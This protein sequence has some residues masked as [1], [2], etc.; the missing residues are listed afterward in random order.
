MEFGILGPLEVVEGGVTIDL[1]GLKQRTLLAV[2]LLH[3][4]EVVSSD[5]LIEALWQ[6]EPPDT[7]QKAVQVY[8]SQL[9]K[10][11]GRERLQ[12]RPPGYVLRVDEGELDLARFRTLRAEE[13]PHEALSIWRGPPLGDFAYQ[14][15]AQAEIARL[16]EQRLACLEDRIERD[17]AAG[18]Q[19]DLVGELEELVAD[20]PLRERL[21]GQLMLALYRSGRQAEALNA[22]QEARTALVDELGIEPSRELRD[23]HQAILNQDPALDLVASPAS[24]RDSTRG[25]FVGREAELAELIAGLDDAIAGHGRLFLLVGEPGIGKSRL[26]DEL[27]VR[28]R[29]RGAGV[30]VGRCW[31]AGGAPAYWPWVQS[32]RN[33][34]RATEVDGLR[35]QLGAGATDL[36]QLLPELRELFPDLPE[37][38][39]F[40]SEGARFRLFGAASAFLQSAAQSRPL[41]LVLDDL[42]AADEP[43]LLL[44]QFLARELG[45]SRLLVVAAYRNVDPTPADPLTT[46]LAELVR[47]PMTRSVALSGLGEHEVRR[48]IELTSGESPTDELVAA[49]HEETEGNPLFVVEIVRLLA[50]EGGI[51]QAQT[52]QLAIPQSVRDVIVRRLRHLSEECNRALVLASVLGREFALEA[53]ARVASLSQDELLETLDEAMAAGVVSDAPGD[54]GNLRFAHVLI[55][56]VLYEE[57]PAT[58]RMRLHRRVAEV[59]EEVYA[60]NLEPHLTELAYHFPLAV[61]AGSRGKAIEY[62]RRA[63]D[64]AVAQLAF[65]EAVQLYETALEL[66]E[67]EGTRCELLLALGDA[68][69]RAGDSP[70]AQETF[71]VTAELARERGDAAALALAALGYGGRQVSE[72]AAEDARLISLLEEASKTVGEADSALRARVLARL[73]GALRHEPDRGPRTALSAEAVAIARRVGDA[74]TLAYTLDGRLGAIWW[75]GNHEERLALAAELIEL[76]ASIGDEERAFFGLG[77]RMYAL[78]ELG[79]VAASYGE[80]ERRARIAEQLRQ[81]AQL[82]LV[83]A[84]RGLQSLLSGRFHEAEERVPD[85]RELGERVQRHNTVNAVR[86]QLLV[87]HREQGR[88]GDL[89]EGLADSTP[90]WLRTVVDFELEREAKARAELQALAAADFRDVPR[91]LEWQ[92]ILCLLAEV[93]VGLGERVAAEELYIELAPYAGMAVVSPPELCLGS[94]DRYLGAVASGLERWEDAARHFEH[95]LA[96]NE[97]MGAWPWLAHTQED[98]GRMLLERG[99]SGRGSELISAAL[100][101][102]RELG[103]DSYAARAQELVE[104]Y[105]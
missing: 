96:M 62:A 70:A 7:A 65:Q 73:A 22:Y 92:F 44:L 84:N 30:L 42:H 28:A 10:L 15:F 41:L 90:T 76:A 99:D 98:F 9:R 87:L 78:L 94:I 13:R 46:A 11:L 39:A 58:H 31:E 37:P 55:R 103:M 33:L 95:A 54:P 49:I 60:A 81:P 43:S 72:S 64:R 23:L 52:P 59:L 29:A 75:P 20:H 36:A 85:L 4:N 89:D 71:V 105:T 32:L 16:Q 66:V 25:A 24:E 12:T 27:V 14:Q 68:Q 18:L 8:V 2:L 57:I 67:D 45:Q 26:A 34:I 1:G 3:A 40:E 102:Y 17:L 104:A 38:P 6:D 51:A 83:A 48:F 79:E 53:L 35:V 82:W 80:L 21:R 5:R 91:E 63:G 77:H 100:A 97:R 88:L 56:D 86:H 93:S 19:A 74:S 101:T 47:E 50:A 61:P 69:A